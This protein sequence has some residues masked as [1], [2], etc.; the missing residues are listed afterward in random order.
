MVAVKSSVISSAS[1]GQV[2]D[3]FRQLL[4]GCWD[5]ED[6]KGCD[7]EVWDSSELRSSCRL[8]RQILVAIDTWGLDRLFVC[9]SG[10][11]V[12]FSIEKTLPFRFVSAF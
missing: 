1:T 8:H 2:D 4:E 11:A 5:C 3:C 7:R 10:A 9:R 12:H 6:A